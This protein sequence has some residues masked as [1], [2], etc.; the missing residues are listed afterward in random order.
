MQSIEHGTY[1]RPWL[2]KEEKGSEWQRPLLT[3]RAREQGILRLA[4]RNLAQRKRRY[5]FEPIAIYLQRGGSHR[6]DFDDW[7]EAERELVGPVTQAR[8]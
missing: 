6:Y 4:H 1:G 7:L 8:F 2:T 3:K 5:G